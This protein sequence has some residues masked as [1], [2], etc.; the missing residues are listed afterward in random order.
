MFYKFKRFLN[1]V[2]FFKVVV[3]NEDE[4]AILRDPNQDLT[5]FCKASEEFKKLVAEIAVL[6][7]TNT[8]QVYMYA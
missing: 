6:Q 3:Q 2:S 5:L 4:E 1:N 7:T 8:Q